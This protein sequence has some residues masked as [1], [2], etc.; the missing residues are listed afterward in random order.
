MDTMKALQVTRP[1][2]F[3]LDEVPI[4]DLETVVPNHLPVL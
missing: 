1:P 4:P 2:T 3:E